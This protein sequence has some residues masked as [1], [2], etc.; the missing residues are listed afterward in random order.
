LYCGGGGQNGLTL[1]WYVKRK[2]KLRFST[3]GELGWRCI[4]ETGLLLK[5]GKMD[6]GKIRA[7]MGTF[8]P[9]GRSSVS[10]NSRIRGKGD[11]RSF[12]ESWRNNYHRAK[13]LGIQCKKGCAVIR[14]TNGL[15][16]LT[17]RRGMTDSLSESKKRTNGGTENGSK[18]G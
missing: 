5:K 12:I 6:Q 10:Q 7:G 15:A 16:M 18:G 14:E 11:G 8:P 2:K 13:T 17:S 1:F 3:T 9:T 4:F